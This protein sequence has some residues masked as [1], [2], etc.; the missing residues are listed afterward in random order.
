MARAGGTPAR[1][2][3]AREGDPSDVGTDIDDEPD[4]DETE[5]L[6]SIDRESSGRGSALWLRRPTPLGRSGG[7]TEALLDTR[8]ECSSDAS[9][10]WSGCG[11]TMGDTGAVEMTEIFVTSFVEGRAPPMATPLTWEDWYRTI[12]DTGSVEADRSLC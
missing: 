3:E 2:V 10:A 4:R 6:A 12:G 9:A 1:T 5:A 7:A 11:L 8:E